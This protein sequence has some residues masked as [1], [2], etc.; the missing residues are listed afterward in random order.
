MVTRPGMSGRRAVFLDRDGVL[1]IPDMRDGRSFAPRRLEDFRYYPETKTRLESLKQAGFLLIVVT[2]QPDVGKGLISPSTLEQMHNRIL[3]ELPV[4]RIEVCTHTQTD[5]CAC[6]KPKPGMLLSAARELQI[7]LES[8]FMVGD[9]ASDVEAG[10]AAG[11][12]TIFI[13][14][15]YASELKPKSAHHMVR[16]IT[17]AAEIILGSNQKTGG[18]ACRA[19]KI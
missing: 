1:V 15:D 10:I 6:R 7:D 5:E 17:E 8:S 12:E 16:S 13:D 18:R 14:L 4:D 2:N 19:S 11:C 9:R 3:Q